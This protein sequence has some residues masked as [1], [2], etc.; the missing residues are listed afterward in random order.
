M[1]AQSVDNAVFYI[2]FYYYR[3]LYAYVIIVFY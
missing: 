3:L 2:Y 1:A